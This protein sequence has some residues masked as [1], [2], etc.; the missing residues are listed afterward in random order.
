MKDYTCLKCGKLF[1][2]PLTLGE[3][4]SETD[5]CP[6]CKSPE[7]TIA[8]FAIYSKSA[9]AYLYD[10]CYQQPRTSVGIYNFYRHFHQAIPTDEEIL[11]LA[12]HY[13]LTKMN[14]KTN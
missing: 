5:V 8:L 2:T 7:F 3:E 10:N 1:E 9:S 14:Y 6:Y 13:H 11:R 4:E 12:E